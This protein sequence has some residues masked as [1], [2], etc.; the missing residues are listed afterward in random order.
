MM[1]AKQGLMVL[2]LCAGILF[3][4]DIG[5]IQKEAGEGDPEAQYKLGLLYYLGQ[6]LSKDPALACDWIKKAAIQGY[7]DAEYFI[8]Y[9]YRYGEVLEKND[10][11]AA[12]WYANAAKKAMRKHRVSWP[13]CTIPVRV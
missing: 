1:R 11:N 4:A 9:C 8:G 5:Q 13:T 10:E 6:N 12:L 3:S 7:P 2:L